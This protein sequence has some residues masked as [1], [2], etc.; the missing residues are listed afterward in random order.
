MTDDASGNSGSPM[1][2]NGTQNTF[3]MQPFASR[4]LSPS[5]LEAGRRP[6]SRPSSRASRSRPES[7]QMPASRL[8][9]EIMIDDGE[10]VP[11]PR[12]PF[13]RRETEEREEVERDVAGTASR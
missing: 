11:S 4:S 9:A 5:R 1:L 8:E 7:L 13:T 3:I 2:A 6:G 12:L 10:V